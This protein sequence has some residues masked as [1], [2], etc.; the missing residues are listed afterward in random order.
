MNNISM[1]DCNEL[2]V[3]EYMDNRTCHMSDKQNEEFA[4]YMIRH[5]NNKDF[6]VHQTLLDPKEYYTVSK[7]RKEA[8]WI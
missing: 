3:P 2:G 6:D 5:M 8:G 7:S 1:L 4:N